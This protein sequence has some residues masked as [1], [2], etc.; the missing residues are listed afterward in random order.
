MADQTHKPAKIYST[1]IRIFKF[2]FHFYILFLLLSS[3]IP[4][5]FTQTE[6]DSQ[7]L[8]LHNLG[9]EHYRQESYISALNF[10]KQSVEIARETGAK[11]IVASNYNR[12]GLIYAAQ[13]DFI[14]ALD[15]YNRGL[16]IYEGLNDRKGI[17]FVLNNLGIIYRNQKNYIK[18]LEYYEKSMAID[19]ELGNK[20]GE[21]ISLNNIGNIYNN[22]GD[23]PR[24]LDLYEQS[25]LIASEIDDTLG[26]AI[27]KNNI[28]DLYK[29]QDDYLKAHRFY[30]ESLDLKKKLGEKQGIATT[31]INIGN[32]YYL[33]GNYTAAINQSRQALILGQEL[34]IVPQQKD[35]YECLYKSHKA[36]NNGNLAL[37]YHEQMLRMDDSLKAEE[38][39][40]MIERMEFR[41]QITADS[42]AQAEKDRLIQKQPEEEV[43]HENR[44]RKRRSVKRKGQ[45]IYWWH[46]DYYCF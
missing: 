45:E 40:K 31:L 41:K 29:N 33:Q 32:L 6:K 42:I 10:C 24:A 18:A 27:A 38:T 1:I 13:G 4:T 15:F 26:I 25:I 19:K 46:Q 9:R 17:S 22:I 35:A 37:N 28:G 8:A 43:S 34:G 5:A 30:S 44:T 12:I 3:A 2:P 23:Y 36:L 14:K 20:L 39:A 11:S 7:A 21:E 16:N